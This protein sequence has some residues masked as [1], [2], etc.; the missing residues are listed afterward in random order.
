M[1]SPSD[2]TLVIELS[3]FLAVAEHAAQ[4]LDQAELVLLSV[5]SIGEC[6]R[7]LLA[8]ALDLPAGV[9]V[10]ADNGG[11]IWERT[12][13]EP[14]DS[15]S[16][17]AELRAYHNYLQS[18][19]ERSWLTA[20]SWWSRSTGHSVDSIVVCSSDPAL[21]HS[22]WKTLA[23]QQMVRERPDAA[24]AAWQSRQVDAAKGRLY[25][26]RETGRAGLLAGLRWFRLLPRTEATPTRSGAHPQDEATTHFRVWAPKW[27]RVDVVQR[28]RSYRLEADQGV[29]QGDV[30]V[31]PGALYQFALNQQQRRPDPTARF[32]PASV[33]THSRVT[34]PCSFPWTDHDWQGVSK[35]D[36][37]VYELHLGAFS[38][39]G[40]YRGAI[41]RIP[42]LKSLGAT[43]IELLPVAQAPGRWNWGY[44]GV[45]LYAPNHNYGSP[46]E[47]KLL[48]DRCHRE[49]LAVLLDVVYNHLGPEGNYLSEFGPYFSRKHHTPWGGAVNFDGWQSTEV[50]RWVVENAVYWL[51]EF[52]FDG[53]RLDA[54]HFMFDDSEV[55][56]L[57]EVRQATSQY[58][59]T[60]G[61]TI[62]LIAES[63]MYDHDLAEPEAGEAYDAMWSDCMMHSIYALGAPDV[64]LTHRDY[65]GAEDLAEALQDGYLYEGPH[66]RRVSPAEKQQRH[67]GRRDYLR[68]LVVALQTHD[69]VGNHPHGKRLH[70]LTSPAF[71]RAAAALVLLYPAT[72][73][74]FMGEESGAE[75]PF[76]FFADFGDPGLRSRVDEGRAREYPQHQWDGAVAPSDPAAF[77]Q[78]KCDLR[79]PS[80]PQTLAWYR[81]L[82]EIRR[83]GLAGGWLDPSRFTVASTVEQHVFRLRYEASPSQA[84]EVA[85]CLGESSRP[86]YLATGV[87]LADSHNPYAEQSSAESDV[88]LQPN[89]ALVTLQ[90]GRA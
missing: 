4:L 35:R 66:V 85:V 87:L 20:L 81:R 7:Q 19:E 79:G 28:N 68:S 72:P 23:T 48:V 82:L 45:G 77:F 17:W 9:R 15:G 47:L 33:H 67:Q 21:L 78:A 24:I 38:R 53:L 31:G 22:R 44:D 51:D 88:R 1:P 63:N 14:S 25:F 49:G 10:I 89:H 80:D 32:Q 30:S 43:A 73:M 39:S 12:L 70:H 36:L 57:Q 42:Y 2:R 40:D 74:I 90:S 8:A 29:H 83:D 69:S 18:G 59:S 27:K 76:P 75:A 61:R 54:V 16:G 62:H 3:S 34:S 56:I 52:H 71:H 86:D 37:V 64:Q 60:A 11:A 65:R 41:E 26:A 50:R 58:Q 6:Q 5:E 84:V 13:R 55:S 46:D